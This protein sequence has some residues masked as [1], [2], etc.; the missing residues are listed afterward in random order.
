MALVRAGMQLAQQQGYSTV[1]I[2]TVTARGIVEHLGWR[3]LRAV[4]HGDEQTVVYQ[5][6][7]EHRDITQAS[8]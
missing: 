8:T 2:A 5:C 7:L 4:T 6:G 3:L 1:Y